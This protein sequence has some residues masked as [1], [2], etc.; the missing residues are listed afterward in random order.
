[1]IMS[2]WIINTLV[3][4]TCPANPDAS[5]LSDSIDNLESLVLAESASGAVNSAE[6]SQLNSPSN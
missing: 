6:V 2:V 3:S 5:L 1:M 4:A